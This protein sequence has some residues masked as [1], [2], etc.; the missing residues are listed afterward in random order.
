MKYGRVTKAQQTEIV[1]LKEELGLPH[2]RIAKRL[3][4]SP[5][6][7][8]YWVAT[9]CLVAPGEKIAVPVLSDC[10]RGGRPVRRFSPEEDALIL[11]RVEEGARMADIARE[12]GRLRSSVDGRIKSLY[13]RMEIAKAAG[14]GSDREADDDVW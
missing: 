1:F 4:V 9:L 7:V 5:S 8:G 2:W 6:A 12:L 10:V 3:G 11:R 14:R 13:R